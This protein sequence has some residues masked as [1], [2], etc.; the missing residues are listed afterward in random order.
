MKLDEIEKLLEQS[1]STHRFTMHESV[2]NDMYALK[3]LAVAKAAKYMIQVKD[4]HDFD[5]VGHMEMIRLKLEDLEKG[6]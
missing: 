6:E 3:L 2:W 5:F 4:K 1:I